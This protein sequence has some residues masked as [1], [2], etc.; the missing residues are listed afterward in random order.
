M[1]V[2]AKT[3]DEHPYIVR[4]THCDVRIQEAK[5]EKIRC[6]QQSFSNQVRL[7]AFVSF[8]LQ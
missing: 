4:H 3:R 5:K 8:I 6:D 7:N 1:V 2:Q